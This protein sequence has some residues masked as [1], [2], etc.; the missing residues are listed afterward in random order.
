[1]IT[2]VAH[3]ARLEGLPIAILT[4]LPDVWRNN[5]DPTDVVS[6]VERWFYIKRRGWTNASITHLKYENGKRRHLA[7]QMADIIGINLEPGWRPII[8]WSRP[9]NIRG[10]YIVVQNSCRGARYI[11][12]TKEW[13]QAHWEELTER[14]SKQ[15]KIV[16]LGTSL[17]PPLRCCTDLRGRTTIRQAAETLAGA[18]LFVGL[19][20][21]LMHL[22]A[23]VRTTA[24]IIFGGRT[25]PIET[26]Y[27]FNVNITRSPEC[28][29]CGLNQG[30]LNDLVCLDIPVEEVESEIYKVIRA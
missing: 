14:L 26:G 24:V 17:D 20:S 1:M 4:D 15:F 2:A 21:G 11:S 5:P 25:R 30:C 29:G 28:A 19:E 12:D 16:Q 18:A 8:P 23:A 22:A 6:N 10:Q 13:A 9:R 7:E 27:P 3:Q